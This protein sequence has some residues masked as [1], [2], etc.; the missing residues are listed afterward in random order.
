MSSLSWCHHHNTQQFVSSHIKTPLFI[1][2]HSEKL[3][4]FLT[5]QTS[6]FLKIHQ[7]L[8]MNISR[9]N[10]FAC[11]QRDKRW[12]LS[13]GDSI[14]SRRLLRF[15]SITASSLSTGE[16][17]LDLLN[18]TTLQSV[19]YHLVRKMFSQCECCRLW[20]C[21]ICD[22]N[23]WEKMWQQKERRMSS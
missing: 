22:D 5:S 15:I 14:F 21:P 9:S 16:L 10:P 12:M 3:W 7:S 4:C 18:V 20:L 19:A 11:S 17:L 1:P 2:W 8:N 23:R 13:G 6:T